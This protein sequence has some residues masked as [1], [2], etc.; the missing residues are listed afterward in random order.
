MDRAGLP[1]AGRAPKEPAAPGAGHAAA[2]LRPRKGRW[3]LVAAAALYAVWL[4]V[5]VTAVIVHR[6][7]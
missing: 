3:A 1:E 6:L 5:L 4:A 7:S 2:A